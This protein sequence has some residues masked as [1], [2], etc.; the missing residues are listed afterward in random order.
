MNE[1]SL[2]LERYL[3]RRVFHFDLISS[4][5]TEAKRLAAS[6]APAGS[7]VIA[8]IQTAG[9]GRKGDFWHSGAGGLWFSL[10]LRPSFG[11]DHAESFSLTSA[12]AVASVLG[13]HVP[14]AHFEIK[15]PNDV[16]ARGPGGS[17][18]KV[19]GLLIEGSVSGGAYDWLIVGLGLN[20]NN[21][22]PP[23]LEST[24]TTLE[25]IHGRPVPRMPLLR[26]LILT[27]FH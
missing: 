10:I 23:E 13:R 8:R 19:C 4:T 12:Q 27:L 11:P 20:V 5:Q 26:D 3:Q 18:K 2:A 25:R 7:L 14:G 22:L 9:Y 6:G 17:M 24:A 16:L 15:A 1:E 21:D